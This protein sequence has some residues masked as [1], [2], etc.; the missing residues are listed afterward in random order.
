MEKSLLTIDFTENGNFTLFNDS[1]KNH[2]LKDK[3]HKS[4]HIIDYIYPLTK[5][6]KNSYEIKDHINLSGFNPL[7][8]ANFISLTNIYNSKKGIVVCGLPNNVH[9]N[10]HEKKVLSTANIKAYC[11]NLIVTAIFAASLGLK[12][13]A[14]GIIKPKEL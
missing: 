7:K 12:I 2:I 8:G 10:I 4:I 13:K 14:K 9:P 1:V 6:S 5:L 3:F 11:Y